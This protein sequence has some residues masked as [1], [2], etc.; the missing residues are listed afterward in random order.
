MRTKSMIRTIVFGPAMAAAVLLTAVPGA[1]ATPLCTNVTQTMASYI[2]LGSGGC[3]IGNDLFFDFTYSS[4]RSGQAIVPA[5]TASGEKF[6]VNPISQANGVV[7]FK[8]NAIAFVQTN[9]IADGTATMT[10]SFQVKLGEDLKI[11]GFDTSDAAATSA[12][13]TLT[14]SN[15]VVKQG[16]STLGTVTY[17]TNGS[18]P[19]GLAG[20]CCGGV[21]SGTTLKVTNTFKLK[22]PKTNLSSFAHIS[23]FSDTFDETVVV[24]EPMETALIGGGL[25]LL[26][27]LGRWKAKKRG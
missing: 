22:A 2:A 17:P 18:P 7:G 21:L 1:Q 10:F 9:G 23:N 24:P 14:G 15:V 4:S 25:L 8:F 3:L 20:T 19:I 26:A 6:A 12:T 16:S 13:G 5:A 11:P 27:S